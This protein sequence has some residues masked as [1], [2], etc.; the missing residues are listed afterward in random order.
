MPDDRNDPQE[1][2]S[3]EELAEEA[4]EENPD[5]ITRRETYELSLM[6]EGRAD[7]GRDIEVDDIDPPDDQ[8]T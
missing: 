2:P 1:R 6:E 4:A 8:G 3:V 5:P 7:E